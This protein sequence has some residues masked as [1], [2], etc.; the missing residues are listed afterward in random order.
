MNV[1][2]SKKAKLLV[3]TKKYKDVIKQ[4]EGFLKKLGFADSIEIREERVDIP[5]NAVNVVTSEMEIF[6]PFTDL[7]DIKEEIARLEKEKEKIVTQKEIT[8]K[9]L[10]NP[11]FVSKAPE[12]KVK[13]EKE[14]QAKFNEMLTA[15]NERIENLKNM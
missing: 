6:I 10:S 14:K 15:I 1:H 5:K 8:D 13:E 12:A 7:V 2:P 9:M 4:S 11:G 3:I